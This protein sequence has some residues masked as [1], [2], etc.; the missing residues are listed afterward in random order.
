MLPVKLLVAIL[1]ALAGA[2][3]AGRTLGSTVQ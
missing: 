1:L 2:A 3:A